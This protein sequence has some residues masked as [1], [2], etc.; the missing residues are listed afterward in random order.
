MCSCAFRTFAV[1]ND[2]KAVYWQNLY[3]SLP[4]S[5]NYRHYSGVVNN[6]GSEG[7][8]WSSSSNSERNA[9]N[10]NFNSNN[11]NPQNNNSKGNGFTVRCVAQ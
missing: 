4:F 2:E 9:Y 5:G 7:D 3:D 11:L 8:F 10:L 6:V 1:A